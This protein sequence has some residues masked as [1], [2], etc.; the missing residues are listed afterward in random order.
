MGDGHQLNSSCYLTAIPAAAMVCLQ[1]IN[2]VKVSYVSLIYFGNGHTF[3]FTSLIN[4][5]EDNANDKR[6]NERTSAR[7]RL[8]S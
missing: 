2:L 1:Y 4:L 7:V 8:L 3:S 5:V 6:T